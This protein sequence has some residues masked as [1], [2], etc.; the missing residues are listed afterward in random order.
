MS[1]AI[2][3]AG[4]DAVEVAARL[5][6]HL[7]A[8]VEQSRAALGAALDS[9]RYLSL[10]D[11]LDELDHFDVPAG[12]KAADRQVKRRTAK[13]LTRADALLDTAER[14]HFTGREGADVALHRARKA[15]KRARYAAEVFAPSVGRP[16]KRLVSRLTALQDLLGVHQ[17]TVVARQLLRDLAGQAHAAGENGFG[18]GLLHARQEYAGERVLDDLPVA[19]RAARRRKVRQWLK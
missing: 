1:R 7:D 8:D 10:L 15:Y 13:A 19:R 9:A 4:A 2:D 17:D 18:Y 16:A 14:D 12:A 6:A 3:E 11:G 5:R